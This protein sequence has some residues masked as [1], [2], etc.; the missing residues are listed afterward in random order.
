MH[1]LAMHA[2]DLQKTCL[3]TVDRDFMPFRAIDLAFHPAH[4]CQVVECDSA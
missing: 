2:I 4:V 1:A 3:D